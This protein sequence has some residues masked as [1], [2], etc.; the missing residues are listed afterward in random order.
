MDQFLSI[1][2]AYQTFI[3][4]HAWLVVLATFL[5]PFIEAAVPTLPLGTIVAINLSLM[6]AAFGAFWGTV[7]TVILSVLG[8]FIGMFMIFLIIRH[9]LADKFAGKVESNEIGKKFLNIAHG[10]NIGMML[11]FLANPFMPSSIL[12]YALSFTKIKTG[13]YIW[14]NILS[15]VIIMSFMVFLGSVFDIQNNPE[16]V[17][18]L[19]IAYLIVFLLIFIYKQISKK[20]STKKQK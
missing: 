15:R 10:S 1:I 6:A 7:L 9:R 19:S 4:N 18:W 17:I 14:M 16:N 20:I 2:D 5:L 13:T 12:N 3:T 8:S 11:V